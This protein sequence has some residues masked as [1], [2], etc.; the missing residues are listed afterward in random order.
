MGVEEGA[1]VGD[2]LGPADRVV[3]ATGFGAVVVADH[4]GAVEGVVEAAP[5]G[6]R[7]VEGVAGVVEGDDELRAGDGGDLGVDVLGP[8]RDVGRGVVEVADA[9]QELDV[10][11]VIRLVSMRGVPLVDLRLELVAT[12]QQR[13]VAGPQ[14]AD[15]R[16]QRSPEV[17]RRD[18]AAG[19]ELCLHELVEHRGDLEGTDRDHDRRG[20][21]C[22]TTPDIP[23]TTG[24]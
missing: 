3:A 17:G 11:R 22:L 4:V 19:C 9:A 13:D 16:L 12:S 1:G 15:D 8:D 10:G 21:R 24:V 18:P 6:V 7:G 2:D 14:V 23:A 20:Y 5:A